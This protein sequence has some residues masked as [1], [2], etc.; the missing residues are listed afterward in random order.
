MGATGV[1]RLAGAL[2][3]AARK[4]LKVWDAGSLRVRRASDAHIYVSFSRSFW[5]SA[6]CLVPAGFSM[7]IQMAASNTLVQSM[8]PD[9]YAGA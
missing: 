7:M 6:A 1:G 3:L 4:S 8:V 5:L 9:N 2:A